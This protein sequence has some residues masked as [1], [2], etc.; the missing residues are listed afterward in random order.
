MDRALWLLLRLRLVGQLRRWVRNL[1]TL[2]GLLLTLVGALLF[3]P[4]V[5]VSVFAPRVQLAAQLAL[6]RRHGALVLFALFLVNL[7]LTSEERAVYF[8]PAE[9]EFLFTGPFHRRQ[10]LLYRMAGGVFSSVCAALLMVFVFAHHATAFLPAFVGLFLMIEEMVLITM[11]LGLL[12][13]TLGALAFNRQRK[14]LLLALATLLVIALL[15][16]GQG[17]LARDAWELLDRLEQ[18]RVIQVLASPF[19]PPV[20]AFTATTLWPELA[21]WSLVGLAIVLGV[22]MVILAL[23]AEYYEATAAASTR[24]YARIRAVRRGTAMSRP[25]RNRLA[26]PMLPWWGGLGPAL[27]RQLTTAVRHPDRFGFLVLLC[28]WGCAPAFLVEGR[29][30]IGV[31]HAMLLALVGLLSISMVAPMMIGFSFRADVDRMDTLKSLPIP[32]PALVAGELAVPVLWLSLAEML[33]LCVVAGWHRDPRGLLEAL[34]F[35]PLYN[36]LLIGLEAIMFLWFPSRTVPGSTL[37]FASLGRQLLALTITLLFLAVVLGVSAGLGAL[38]YYF[39]V[40]SWLVTLAVAW[41]TLAGWVAALLPLAVLAFHQFD[42]ARDTP[43]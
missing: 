11:A 42:V 19:Q 38:V 6:I 40:S 37:D 34:L 2:K 22:A 26:L 27:W 7:V 17:P 21:G 10:L 9:V 5:V 41:L 28:L 1:S 20:M 24:I 15:P 23:D 14:L 8:S 35:L 16:R 29:H 18:S 33:S 36:A 32:A 43:P 25:V 30:G 39:V 13:S 31:Q 3:L 12:V 4:M